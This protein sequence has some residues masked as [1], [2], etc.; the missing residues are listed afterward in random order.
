MLDLKQAYILA[1]LIEKSNDLFARS[2]SCLF[3]AHRTSEIDTFPLLENVTLLKICQIL[4]LFVHQVNHL[5]RVLWRLNDHIRSIRSLWV[6]NAQIEF[7]IDRKRKSTFEKSHLRLVAVKDLFLEIKSLISYAILI[8]RK[9][10][11]LRTFDLRYTLKVSYGFVSSCQSSNQLH[12]TF[13]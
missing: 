13:P 7:F 6:K 1:T 5:N 3:P 2:L 8:E 4:N 11:I 12:Y 10:L 9:N